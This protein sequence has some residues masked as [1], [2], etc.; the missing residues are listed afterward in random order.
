MRR[1]SVGKRRSSVWE[2]RNSVRVWRSSYISLCGLAQLVARQSVY[3][4]EAP[5]WNLGLPI[6]KYLF[7][8]NNY[9]GP[10]SIFIYPTDQTQINRVF[11]SYCLK[12]FPSL[13][14]CWARTSSP[15]SPSSMFRVQFSTTEICIR[16]G[17]STLGV[18]CKKRFAIF[19]SPAGMSLTKLSLAGNNLI[20]PGQREFGFSDIPAGDGN[21]ANHFF[22]VYSTMYSMYLLLGNTALLARGFFLQT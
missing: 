11:A 18:R 1:S 20:I 5:S 14:Y 8:R 2:R 4:L 10:T 15:S 16:V 6:I 19:P 22:T 7:S 12:A 17:R 21:I 3:C 13:V 9:V